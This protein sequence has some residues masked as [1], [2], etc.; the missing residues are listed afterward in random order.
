MIN[1]SSA[2]RFCEKIDP[3]IDDGTGRR[4]GLLSG[5]F[6]TRNFV[7]TKH[8]AVSSASTMRYANAGHYAKIPDA[9]QYAKEAASGYSPK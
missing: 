9:T 4:G 6:A 3:G 5:V 8:R 7:S 2:V 1:G